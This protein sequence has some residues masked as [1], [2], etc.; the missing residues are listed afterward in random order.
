M[1]TKTID[2]IEHWFYDVLHY[3]DFGE[4][5]MLRKNPKKQK[6]RRQPQRRLDYNQIMLDVDNLP[7]ESQVRIYQALRRLLAR[8]GIVL[9]LVLSATMSQMILSAIWLLLTRP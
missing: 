8:A 5:A 4:Y 3:P 7:G 1:F 2:K 6:R 9:I